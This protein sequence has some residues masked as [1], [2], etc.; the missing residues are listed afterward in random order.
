MG[1]V[2]RAR[3][4]RLER[5][6]AVKVLP[7]RLSLSSESRQRFER[8]AKTISILSDPHI[9]TVYDVGNQDGVEYLVM[10]YLE[11][12][13]L[14]ERLAKGPLPF[15]LT[16]RYGIEIA[17]AL[18]KAH[19]QGIVHRD[20]KPGNVMLTKSGVKLLDFGLAKAVAPAAQPGTLTSLPTEMVQSHLTQE[21]TILGTF[22]YMAPEQLEGR[23]ADGRTDI[24]AFGAVLYEMA[25]G[26]KAFSG[27]TQASL[28]TAIMSSEPALISGVQSAS[29]AVLDYVVKT[30]LK[31]S[32]DD[33]WQSAADVKHALEWVAGS[34][35]SAA[36]PGVAATRFGKWRFVAAAAVVAALAAGAFVA[37]QRTRP[38]MA[39]APVVR[40]SLSP[41]PGE[42]FASGGAV[43]AF[44][45]NGRTIAA[46]VRRE[47]TTQISIRDVG[48]FDGKLLP[49]T[50]GAFFPFFSP[51]GG[52]LG[53]YAD[54]KLKKIPADGGPVIIL[55]S[56][57]E[58]AG[59][60]WLADETIV[61]SG[62][63]R[64]GLQQVSAA[65]GTPKFLTQ[66]DPARGESYHW[67]PDALPGGDAV[68]FTDQKGASGSPG[69]ANVAVLSLKT[70]KWQTIIEKAT[71]PH[72]LA[73]GYLVY[74]R[75]GVL[76]AA[77]FNANRLSVAGP[78]VPI[79]QGVVVDPDTATTQVA[80]SRSG[81]V[82]Y[83]AGTPAPPDS[84]LV[85]VDR[86]GNERPL[87]GLLRPYE[88]LALS[89][90]GRF[91]ALT[92][93]GEPLNVWLYDLGRDTLGRFTFEGD[94][95]DPIWASDSRR[96]IYIAG[97]EN[98]FHLRWKPIDGSGP[99]EELIATDKVPMAYSCSPD[100]RWLSYTVANSVYLL[101][102]VGEERKPKAIA[103]GPFT[104]GGA[105]SPDGK[106]IA[107]QSSESGQ[108][109]VYVQPLAGAGKW[110]ISVSGGI[111][112]RWSRDGSELFFR[113]GSQG[114]R[115]SLM[116]AP[117]QQGATFSAGTPRPLFPFRYVQGG[118]DYAVMPDG[119][120]F[121][122]IKR[123]EH[124]AGSMHANVIVN[125]AAELKK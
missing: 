42:S 44:S 99:E 21:G 11:G 55:C 58:G 72:F 59:A 17:Q 46:V 100:G 16:L 50:E 24:F 108:S 54:G 81:S 27:A 66:P 90:D 53:F 5:T 101:P 105:I 91:L 121:I 103:S 31:K 40:F 15:D 76:L 117:V 93:I 70:G 82:V 87:T 25:T 94:N 106:W 120:H 52:W 60:T 112:P 77:P 43:L 51:D 79:L 22:Q 10:E 18:D 19:R 118:H 49:G 80:I 48:S 96:V 33:R 4:T 98:R 68:L 84:T 119:Q 29:P 26:K 30:C 62:D 38:R 39:P 6:V 75:D 111:R 36:A 57:P 67:L 107:Y 61:F 97:R 109:E 110:Q 125:F 83:L 69:E 13:T 32:P 37:G 85:V 124:E 74:E 3:D 123:P 41:S 14:A 7:E 63:W 47:G 102:L 2:Y 64:E 116:S 45:P 65:G 9:C 88:D 86:A 92:V 122:C 71:N 114:G 8:E 20:L 28:I 113:S 89:P 78:S 73:G 34:A 1:E 12:E 35:G 23:E 95:R 56:A 115:S 104:F